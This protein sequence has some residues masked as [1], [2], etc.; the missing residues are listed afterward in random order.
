M[1]VL[2]A[3]FNDYAPLIVKKSY[4]K[5]FSPCFVTHKDS[6]EKLL[7][8]GIVSSLE[9]KY[10]CDHSIIYEKTF[11]QYLLSRRKIS[12]Y[13]Y[14]EYGL[15][16]H[17]AYQ[18]AKKRNDFELLNLVKRN[19]DEGFIKQSRDLV[20]TDQATYGN[21]AIDLYQEY[22]DSSY[23]KIAD[24]LY[25]NL[26]KQDSI[27]GL[28]LYRYGRTHQSVD[29]IGL[30]SP[31]L[32]YY[33]KVFH[34]HSAYTMAEKMVLNYVKYG[35]DYT[36]GIPAQ[37]YNLKTHFKK[38]MSNWG[39][40]ISWYLMG[41]MGVDSLNEEDS[42]MVSKLENSLLQNK[43]L[44]YPQ[45]MGDDSDIDLSATIP[46]L[47]YLNYRKLINLS[48][49][50]YAKLISPF[51]DTDGIIRFCT[52]SIALPSERPN[53]FQTSIAFQGLALLLLCEL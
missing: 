10:V 22:G 21:V 27:D 14:G 13:E 48:A 41:V 17:N 23:K 51:I 24:D 25:K 50:R 18:Y 26:A 12:V 5:M 39:R 1:L 2:F 53:A 30:T 16:L 34:N 28:I 44:L 52:P 4:Q 43:N 37:K 38:G 42:I 35:T 49:E 36:S 7:R 11:F 3:F 32:F 15:L 29:V 46:I 40:G 31:F 8:N 47:Y 45:Y 33:A 19:F 20:R 6:L 9:E